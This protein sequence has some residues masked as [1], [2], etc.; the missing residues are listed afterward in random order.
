MRMPTRSRHRRSRC[1]RC[2]WCRR[3]DGGRNE[4]SCRRARVSVRQSTCVRGGRDAR[5]SM[6]RSGRLRMVGSRRRAPVRACHRQSLV[7]WPDGRC[8]GGCATLLLRA[9]VR[10]TAAVHI[11]LN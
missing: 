6:R 9:E 11:R 1:R 8:V 7:A 5:W 10:E 3:S 4:L 2:R